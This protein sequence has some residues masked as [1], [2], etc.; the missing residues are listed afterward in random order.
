MAKG[1]CLINYM[2][3]A[4]TLSPMARRLVQSV[5]LRGAYSRRTRP[6][7][8]PSDGSLLIQMPRFPHDVEIRVKQGRATNVAIHVNESAWLCALFLLALAFHCIMAA[9]ARSFAV[10]RIQCPPLCLNN[11]ASGLPLV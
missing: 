10:R 2:D 9:V 4:A 8:S 3:H 1:S 6:L 11:A 5:R 7:V